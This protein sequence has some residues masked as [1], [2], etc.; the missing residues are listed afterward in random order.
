MQLSMSFYDHAQAGRLIWFTSEFLQYRGARQRD[1]KY[2]QRKKRVELIFFFFHST[3]SYASRDFNVRFVS[4][5]L[6][7]TIS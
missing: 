2:S 7:L 5:T 4:R 1:I 3:S 6:T